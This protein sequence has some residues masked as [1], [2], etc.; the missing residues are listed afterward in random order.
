MF[1][2]KMILKKIRLLV[3]IM[4]TV[5]SVLLMGG[6]ILFPDERIHQILGIVLFVFW[7]CHFVLNRRWYGSLFRGKY[8]PYRILQI[9]INIGLLTCALLLIV[10]GMMIAWFFPINIGTW[11]GFAQTTHLVSSHWYYLLMCA[12]I[13]MHIS[14]IFAQISSRRRVANIDSRTIWRKWRRI[15]FRTGV[16]LCCIYGVYA[17]VNCGIGKYMFMRQEFF[18][19]DLERGYILFAVDYLSILVL[20]ATLSHYFGK[21]LTRVGKRKKRI[22]AD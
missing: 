15:L 2:Y 7:L 14:T 10:S 16:A 17:F 18:F 13:G 8:Q 1:F 21:F 19:L 6:T 4:M 22:R 20:I 11:L 3:D 5:L 12:H 9:V